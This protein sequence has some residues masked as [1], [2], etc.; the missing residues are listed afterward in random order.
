MECMLAVGNMQGNSNSETQPTKSILQEGRNKKVYNMNHHPFRGGIP[1]KYVRGIP[2]KPSK[3]KEKTSKTPPS[4][5]M[6][7][8]PP[9]WQPL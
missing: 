1:L 8:G 5:K 4:V 6:S 9:P 2:P 7:R 3:T